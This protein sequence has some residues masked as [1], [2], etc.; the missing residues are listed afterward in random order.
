MRVP[1][2]V[3]LEYIDKLVESGFE[4]ME[5]SDLIRSDIELDLDIQEI[6]NNTIEDDNLSSKKRFFILYGFEYN[7]K[8]GKNLII[9]SLD[10]YDKVD[11][12]YKTDLRGHKGFFRPVG[13]YGYLFYTLSILTVITTIFSSISYIP[14]NLFLVNCLSY[15]YFS[16][17]IDTKFNKKGFSEFNDVR[18][19]F[20][21][22]IS[23]LIGIGVLYRIF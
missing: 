12:I 8:E 21:I 5:L 23:I 2:N 19:V 10:E 4:V 6:I 11:L 20:F 16:K 22:V 18:R 14:L 3:D 17:E 1:N 7:L 13:F 9:Y 15:Y